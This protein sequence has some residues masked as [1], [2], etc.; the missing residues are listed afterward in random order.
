[1]AQTEFVTSPDA[2]DHFAEVLRAS[3]YATLDEWWDALDIRGKLSRQL[4]PPDAW[5]VVYG[6]GG[7]FPAAAYQRIVDF[8]PEPPVLDQTLYWMVVDTEE[9]AAYLT[10]MVNSA[11]LRETIDG[12]IPEGAFGPRHLH[13]LPSKGIPQFDAAD[14]THA[15]V[16][17]A[18]RALRPEV[19]ALAAQPDHAHLFKAS[20]GLASRRSR[21]RALFAGLPAFAEYDTAC[22][23]VL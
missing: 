13:T 23:G 18:V 6:A 21:L 14:G 1:L 3:D 7:S 9:E 15:R 16:A 11:V 17:A 22:R 4:M 2:R 10:G 5:L 19:L 8:G 12:F 20:D